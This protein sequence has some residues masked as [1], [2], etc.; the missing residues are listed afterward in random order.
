[1]EQMELLRPQKVEAN[2]MSANIWRKMRNLL[3]GCFIDGRNESVERQER[4][5][6]RRAF[7]FRHRKSLTF[8]WRGNDTCNLL[9]RCQRSIVSGIFD[10]EMDGQAQAVH[11]TGVLKCLKVHEPFDPHAEKCP[12]TTLA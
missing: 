10:K 9:Q 11:G 12:T 7:S 8:A 5:V 2:G 6:S 4:C 3:I 1:M